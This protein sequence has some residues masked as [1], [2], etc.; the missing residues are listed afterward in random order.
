MCRTWICGFV[1]KGNYCWMA[2]LLVLQ[3]RL[4]GK[5]ILLWTIDLVK[6]VWDLCTTHEAKSTAPTVLMLLVN[7]HFGCSEVFG[8]SGKIITK[9]LASCGVEHP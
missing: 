8:T 7:Q 5:I 6:T 1:V 9:P 3:T 4:V 2:D